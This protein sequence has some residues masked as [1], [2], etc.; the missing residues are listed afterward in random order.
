[1]MR[2]KREGGLELEVVVLVVADG[3]REH[4]GAVLGLLRLVVLV[5]RG[6]EVDAGAALQGGEE[7]SHHARPH[8]PRHPSHALVRRLHA[9]LRVLLRCHSHARPLARPPAALSDFRSRYARRRLRL[10]SSPPSKRKR[11]K[12]G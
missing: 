6:A 7:G 10:A 5:L 1:M 3:L 2:R 4:E 12:R 8:P 11:R 9:L